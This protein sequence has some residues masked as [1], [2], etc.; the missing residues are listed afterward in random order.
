MKPRKAISLADTLA[1]RFIPKTK[2]TLSDTAKPMAH[3]AAS[4]LEK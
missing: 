2:D 4:S 1:P 3:L